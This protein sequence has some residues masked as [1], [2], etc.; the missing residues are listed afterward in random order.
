MNFEINNLKWTREP[1]DYSIT[2]DKIEIIT[3]PY[4]DVSR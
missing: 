1:A 4:T 2:K 3:N